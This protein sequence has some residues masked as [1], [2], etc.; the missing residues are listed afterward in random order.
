[1]LVQGWRRVF[2]L[3]DASEGDTVRLQ[4]ISKE[5]P[6]LQLSLISKAT[7]DS[8]NQCSR[9]QQQHWYQGQARDCYMHQVGSSHCGL[10]AAAEMLDFAIAPKGSMAHAHSRVYWRSRL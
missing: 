4:F 10:E 3:L 6:R 2:E 1:M 8:A 5:W 9:L 7:T